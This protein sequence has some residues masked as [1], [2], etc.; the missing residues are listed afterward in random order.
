MR[1]V[2]LVLALWSLTGWYSANS[3]TTVNPDISVIGD[4]RAFSHDDA[5]RAAEAEELNLADPEIELYVSGYLNPYARAAAFIGWHPGA[6]A[7]IEEVYVEFV[8]GLPLGASVR[9]GKYLLEFGRLNPVHPHAYSFVKRPLPHE[10]FFGDEGLADVAVRSSFLLPTGSAYT[11]LMGGVLKG[12]ALL[13]HGHE[14]EEN[15]G[16]EQEEARPDLGFFGRLTTSVATSEYGEL[17]VGASVLNSVHEIAVHDIAVAAQQ[18]EEETEQLRSWV[19]GV[20]VKYRHRSSR[21]SAIQVEAEALLRSQ[22]THEFG[23]LTSYGG[24]GYIDYRFR[25]RY[26]AGGIFE[27]VETEGVHEDGGVES[28]E[29]LNIWRAGLFV[30]FA[31]VEETSLLRLAGHWT[32]PSESDGFWELTLQL[33]FSLGPHQ[34]HNF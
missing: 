25:Q 5:S 23:N 24:Y 34:P 26:N 6:N 8:R 27:Y 31:P 28:V 13:G 3:Q 33:V 11:E 9:A 29:E 10:L 15:G 12:D 2:I 32:E 16:H 17:A 1:P 14:H 21:Y 7:E 18:Q 19:G 4:L 20:D 22:E 30:G